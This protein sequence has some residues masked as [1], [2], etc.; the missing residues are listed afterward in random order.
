MNNPNQKL[1]MWK[2]RSKFSIVVLIVIAFSCNDEVMNDLME[3]TTQMQVPPELTEQLAIAQ[4]KYPGS[5]FIYLETDRQHKN[6]I[7]QLKDVN[8]QNIAFIYVWADRGRVG[9]LVNKNSRLKNAHMK[10]EDGVFKIVEEPASPKGGYEAFYS[11]LTKK[12]EYTQK[13]RDAGAKGTVYVQF[14][15]NPDG[16]ITDAQVVRGIGYGLD[17]VALQAIK[18]SSEWNPP[19]QKGTA[20]K[21]RIVM[22][23]KFSLDN[24]EAEDSSIKADESASPVG[25]Y[26]KLYQYINQNL[27]YPAVTKKK[28]P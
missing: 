12:L 7:Q 6:Q 3:T 24:S 28:G 27:N 25:G 23:V 5:E 17:K 1:E 11:E 16:K 8:P 4:K 14:V 19:F 9:A 15:V 2:W 26:D 10:N 13:A 21:Q 22:P 20:V 18:R